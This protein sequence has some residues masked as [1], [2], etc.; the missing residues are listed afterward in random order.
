MGGQEDGGAL[1]DRPAQDALE[2]VLQQRVEPGG[3]LVEDQQLGPVGEGLDDSHLAAVAGAQ[4]A[5]R[6]GRVEV[7]ALQQL[8]HERLVE[9]SPQRPVEGEDVVGAVAGIDAKV[10]REVPDAPADGRVPP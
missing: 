3:G 1:V 5:D 6:A 8:G 9:A 10:A 2:L 4:L 7:E